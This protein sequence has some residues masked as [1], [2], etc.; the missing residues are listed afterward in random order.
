MI[1]RAHG[2]L[3]GGQVVGWIA[4]GA[5]DGEPALVGD[6]QE[7]RRPLGAGRAQ[8]DLEQLV[9]RGVGVSAAGYRADGRK[10]EGVGRQGGPIV[11]RRGGPSIEH[12]IEAHL[13]RSASTRA[14]YSRP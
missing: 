1:G 13:A 4:A 8:G 7:R 10:E 5:G 11:H 2:R 12:P 3:E 6:P 14:V 9:E